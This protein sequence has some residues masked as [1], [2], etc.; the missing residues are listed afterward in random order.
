MEKTKKDLL[1]IIPLLI[2]FVPVIIYAGL[3]VPG[4]D[5]FSN[6]NS[7]RDNLSRYNSYFLTALNNSYS[8][9]MST[10]GYFFGV[11]LNYFFSPFLRFGITGV[12]V[13]NVCSNIFFYSSL[14]YLI[15]VFNKYFLKCGREFEWFL[16][17]IASFSL[18]NNDFNADVYTWYVV[19]VGYMLPL[20]LM[21]LSFGFYIKGMICDSKGYLIASGILFFLDSGTSLNVAAL[22]CGMAL[23]MGFY[24]FFILGKKKESIVIFSLA[25]LGTIINLASPGNYIRHESV[26]ESYNILGSFISSIRFPGGILLRRL[27]SSFLIP[28]L[29]FLFVFTY[30]NLNTE[31]FRFKFRFIY[32]LLGAI[33]C[34]AGVVIVDF[35]VYLGYAGEYFPERCVFVQDITACILIYLCIVLFVGWLK[36]RFRIMEIS[37]RMIFVLLLILVLFTGYKLRKGLAVYPTGYMIT[38]IADGS[39]SEYIDY[40]EELLQEI[41][42]SNEEETVIKK[43]RDFKNPFIQGIGLTDDPE[44]WSNSAISAYYGKGP[45]SLQPADGD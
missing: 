5:D 1:W 17:F 42:S 11:F 33:I 39:L 41:E 37:N 13:F 35:P 31:N 29:M 15:Y 28:E 19:Q 16:F 32:V 7:V 12:R 23:I 30:K 25:L 34:G 18:I 10:S 45:I 43:G 21:F 24:A 4:W 2:L 8:M 36:T 26:S 27:R 22:N 6:A 44:Y 20:S 40:C 9:Y 38:S 14:F 3:S